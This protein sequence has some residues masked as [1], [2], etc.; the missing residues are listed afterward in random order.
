[1]K[2]LVRFEYIELLCPSVEAGT[3]LVKLLSKTERVRSDFCNGK[4]RWI[5]HSDDGDSAPRVELQLVDPSDIQ[6]RIPKSRRLTEK[7]GLE[8]KA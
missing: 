8:E 7:T 1:M 5:P 3:Q 4:R 2:S 6:R